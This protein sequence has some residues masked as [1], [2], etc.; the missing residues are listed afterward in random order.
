MFV[1]CA[2]DCVDDVVRSASQLSEDVAAA[3]AFEA[4]LASAGSAPL[5]VAGKEFAIP[6]DMVTFTFSE[7]MVSSES[8]T[9]SVIEPS[10]GIGRIMTGILEHCFSV[11]PGDEKRRVLSFPAAIAPV[12]CS[13]FPLDQRVDKASVTAVGDSLDLLYISHV[14]DDSSECHVCGRCSRCRP[15]SMEDVPVT[16]VIV[17]FPPCLPSRHEHWQALCTHRRGGHSLRHHG[18]ARHAPARR[19]DAARPR[20]VRPD[21]A[22]G[23][24]GGVAREAALR[25]PHRVLQPPDA[26]Q[27]GD[28]GRGQGGGCGR[29]CC[30]RWRRR[31]VCR[32]VH[33]CCRRRHARLTCER[34]SGGRRPCERALLATKDSHLVSRESKQ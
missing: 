13:V 14:I 7:K 28:D 21:S 29:R 27:G 10:F 34:V 17:F 33:R 32:G 3:R 11:R 25:R 23:D 16:F 2:S 26:L 6:R 30:G 5:T 31:W 1:V 4:Q 18:G 22:A 9:P 24:R 19:G 8:F 20:H 15:V 12:K